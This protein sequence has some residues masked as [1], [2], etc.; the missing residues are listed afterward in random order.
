MAKDFFWAD[1]D[2]SLTK[3]TDGD[4]L[5]DKDVSAIFNSVSNIVLTIQGERRML[6]TFASNIYGLLFE[7]IDAV[8]ARLIAEGLLEAIRVWEDRIEVT[9]FDIEPRP[10]DNFYRCRLNFTIL[11]IEEAQ[12]IDFVLTR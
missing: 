3:Q 6:P 4:V 10:D 9:G 12:S 8:T 7:P 1:V 11:G 5:R 2:D